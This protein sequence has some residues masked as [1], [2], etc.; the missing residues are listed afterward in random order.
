MNE[1]EKLTEKI[2]QR[3]L[4]TYKT[5][6]QLVEQWAARVQKSIERPLTTGFKA[7]DKDL[8]LGLGVLINSLSFAFRIAS[9]FLSLAGQ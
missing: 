1:L 8:D 2:Q 5:P 4:N 3:E 6:E 7:F 9:V